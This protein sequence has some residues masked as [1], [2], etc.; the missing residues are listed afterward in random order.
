MRL[1][2]DEHLDPLLATQLRAR[3]HDVIAVAADPALRGLSDAELLDLGAEQGRAIATYDAADFLPL[4][5][6]REMAGRPC[7]GVILI[8]A[9][10]H[11]PGGRGHGRLPHAVMAVMDEDG[12]E[13]VA[14]NVMWL[15][16][17]S[18]R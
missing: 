15:A 4:I 8:S 5:E 12:S 17:R 10:S 18:A 6:E 3:G 9:R 14:G 16:A 1:L 11:P 7:A 2:L 13:A